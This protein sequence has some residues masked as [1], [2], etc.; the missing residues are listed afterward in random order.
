[1]KEKLLAPFKK[2]MDYIMRVRSTPGQNRKAMGQNF[3]IVTFLIFVVFS[4]RLIWVVA[5]DKVAGEELSSKAKKNFQETQVIQAKRGTI[6]DRHGVPIAIDSSS[7]TVSVIKDER[8]VGVGNVRLYANDDDF[9]KI[10][11]LFKDVLGM[12]SDYVKSQLE[13]KNVNYVYFGNKGSNIDYN[14]RNAI[15]TKAEEEGIKGINF[16][17][18]L[19]R[20]YPNGKFASHFIGVAGL[21]DADDETQG[22]AGQNGLEASLN[23]ILSGTN[24][25]QTF[26]K[27]T[28]GVPLPGTTEST[29]EAVNGSDVYTTL[30]VSLQTYL[31]TLLDKSY[32][33][34][35]AQEVVATLVKADTGEILATSQRPTFNPDTK[36]GYDS[37]NFTWNNLLYQANY[38]PGSTM[39]VFTLASAINQG[40]F[41]PADTYTSGTLKIADTSIHDWDYASNPKGKT[42][43]FAQGFSYS[44]NIGLTL[45]EQKLG[46]STWRDY[47]KRFKFGTSTYMG[48]GHENAGQFPDA[49]VVTTAMSAFGQGIDVTELQMLRGFLSITN[50]GVM[51]EPHYINKIVTGDKVRQVSPEIIGKP[52]DASAAN[53]TLQYM[54]SVGTDPQFGTAYNGLTKAP[55]FQVEG[56]NVSVKTGTAQIAQNGA[57]MT[58]DNNY[59][60]SAV[61]MVPTENPEFIMYMTVK[62]PKT[63]SLSY[64]SDVANPI[65]TRAMEMK[66]TLSTSNLG[67]TNEKIKID[68]YL[69]KD[70]GTVA[71]GLRREILAPVIIGTGD[72]VV[73]QSLSEGTTVDPNRRVLLLTDGD[74]EMPDVFAW[75]KYDIEK[76]AEWMDLD[77]EF[78][79]T[80]NKVIGQSIAMN[81]PLSKNQK[82]TVDLGV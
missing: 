14:T 3:F 64:I 58:G 63:W 1:M 13:N 10:E 7:Y 61:T 15:E 56:Q 49:N 51:L 50:G 34:S 38:E 60:Y 2:M 9:K 67:L 27:N 42:M 57:Y 46:E 70:P 12:D 11:T 73:K 32:A 39:K 26:Q 78:T 5:T 37:A 54:V 75:T 80:G 52:V 23:S 79:G 30:D 62:I 45:L 40:V 33:D 22:L 72:K 6:F 4:G 59:I 17:S 25:L 20:S 16:E 28:S 68:N 69:D 77:L 81:T 31:E 18:H 65:L 47:L 29:K 35:G 55:F 44:S 53:Q 76:F 71:E 66:D 36:T 19:S 8:Y 82:L 43:T 21:R 74:I 24:G 48:V 41:N